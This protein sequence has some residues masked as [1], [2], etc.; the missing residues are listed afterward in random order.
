MV[1][2]LDCMVNPHWPYL[3]EHKKI[4]SSPQEEEDI[5]RAWGSVPDDPLSYHFQYH[6][7]DGDDHGRLP[8]VTDPN[9]GEEVP[10][11][12]FNW[13]CKSAL[14]AIAQSDNKVTREIFVV[15]GSGV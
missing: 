2:V 9:T 7:L 3:P 1:A 15:R 14:R 6:I 13:T 5:E 4:Y 12:H 8:T 11:D 10:N